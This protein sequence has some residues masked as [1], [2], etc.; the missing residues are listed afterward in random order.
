[1]RMS[2]EDTD[3]EGEIGVLCCGKRFKYN[4]KETMAGKGEQQN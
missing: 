2:R 3:S 1:M 4:R